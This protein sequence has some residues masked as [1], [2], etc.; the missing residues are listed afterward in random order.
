MLCGWLCASLH[1]LRGL[2]SYI[3]S[4]F[5]PFRSLACLRWRQIGTED[6]QDLAK[7]MA[8]KLDKTRYMYPASGHAGLEAALPQRVDCGSSLAPPQAPPCQAE[9]L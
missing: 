2:R 7:G 3:L 6:P 1:G 4:W 5:L 9:D 8:L